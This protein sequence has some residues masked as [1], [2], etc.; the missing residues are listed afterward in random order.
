[1]QHTDIEPD[2]YFPVAKH[3]RRTPTSPHLAA[4]PANGT[5]NS[6]AAS[7]QPATADAWGL[8]TTAV[9]EG[10]HRG[11]PDL[12]TAG[13]EQIP[14]AA[15]ASG[16][17]VDRISTMW[18]AR[19]AIV[20]STLLVGVVV[21]LLAGAS[22]AVYSSSATVSITA[23]STPGGSAQDVALAS[24]SLAAQDALLV[25]SDSV[26]AAAARHL[27]ISPSTL[28]SHLSSGT[29]NAQNLIQ[30][31]AQG[32]TGNDALRWARATTS[33]FQAYL[34]ERA[35]TTSS[36]LRNSITA[37]TE[38]LDQ[39]ID[40]LQLVIDNAQSAP[41]ASTALADLQS[42]ENQLTQLVG[43][44]ATLTANT[45]LAIASQQPV[46]TVVVSGT[47]PSKVSPRPTLYATVAALLT[48][49]VACQL[50]IF[51][52]RRKATRVGSP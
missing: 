43:T 16:T 35:Q 51:V 37:E 50:A 28:S 31:T 33:A 36:S 17:D 41:P 52:A 26:V 13:P 38:S 3:A 2:G 5:S 29:L 30:I 8:E 32:P 40:L 23:A 15:H 21:Y 22:A 48:F 10:D 25:T 27:G 6:R 49:L 4:V 42:D 44:R 20:A 39:Q 1:M 34:A 14:A 18:R 46:I 11:S 24:N 7:R 19:Y 45:A 12:G 9:A 47:S